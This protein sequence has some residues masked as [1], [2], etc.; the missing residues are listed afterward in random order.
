MKKTTSLL[1]IFMISVSSVF[2]RDFTEKNLTVTTADGVEM[3]ATITAPS[4]PKAALLLATGSG[5]QNRDEEIFGK[6]PFK[7]IADFLSSN[8][9]AVLRVDDRGISAPEKARTATMQTDID[10]IL[11]S[12]ALL[13]SLYPSLPKGILGHSSGGTCA[14]HIG[15]G[16]NDVDFI[17]TLAAPA[18]RGDSISMSQNRAIA[19]SVTGRW[20]GEQLQRKILDIARSTA[21]DITARPMITM[22]FTEALGEAAKMPQAQ[23][24]IQQQI[25]AV[26]SPW[27]RSML[28]FDPA[29]DIKAI[30][31]P[32]LAL[33]GSKDM[34]VHPDNLKTFR[35]L[36]SAIETHLMPNH[37]HLFQVCQTG[38]MQ[39]Y[40]T[41]PG[42]ISDE[43]LKAILSWLERILPS[44]L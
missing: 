6:K 10:D 27:F 16:Q 4:S 38:M 44:K 28:R 39:E 21:P 18:W 42:D 25:S 26:L 43:T 33:N 15:A 12:F 32:V 22:A 20:D 36:N 8:G 17:I 30:K 5:T 24:Q 11:S 41:L 31:I 35:E 40:A 1:G 29:D 3:G 2:G 7:T 34:Q 37:N 14:I 23:T 9:Y 19:M 13:D